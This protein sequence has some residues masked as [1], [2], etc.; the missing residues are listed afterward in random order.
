LIKRRKTGY[1][2]RF[3]L[4]RIDGKFDGRL[5][6]S[7]FRPQFLCSLSQQKSLF[8]RLDHGKGK[9]PEK[10]D[11]VLLLF[12]SCALGSGAGVC[13]YCMINPTNL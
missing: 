9:R 1:R 5:K 12:S 2:K 11:Y 13:F 7:S 6:G 4:L 8:V 3:Q 10:L